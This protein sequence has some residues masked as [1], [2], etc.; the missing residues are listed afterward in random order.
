MGQRQS[1]PTDTSIAV[2]DTEA[3]ESTARNSSVSQNTAAR[4]VHHNIGTA[5]ERQSNPSSE[6]FRSHNFGQPMSAPH[7]LP[8]DESDETLNKSKFITDCRVRHRA[9]LQCIEE[10][11][12]NR[13]QACASFFDAYKQCR[14]EEHERKLEANAKR[15]GF[16]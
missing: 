7:S 1:S 16:W 6:D 9:S 11:Y 2:N 3:N 15:S 14:K 12:E 10:N 4:N 13:Q 5:L 8:A